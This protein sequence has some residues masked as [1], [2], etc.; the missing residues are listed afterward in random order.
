MSDGKE[1]AGFAG[2]N[3]MVGT[4]RNGNKTGRVGDRDRGGGGGG[5][6]NMDRGAEGIRGE[7]R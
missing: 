7:E 2:V 5:V 3:D 6:V 4:G 1:T